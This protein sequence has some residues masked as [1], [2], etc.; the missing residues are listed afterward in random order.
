MREAGMFCFLAA[1]LFFFTACRNQ[2]GKQETNGAFVKEQSGG[3]AADFDFDAILRSGE[4]IV[5]TMSGPDTYYDFNG[6]ELGTQYDMC[7]LF[8]AQEGL[9]IRVELYNDTLQM[10]H[11][12]KQGDVDL[13]IFQIPQQVLA[14]DKD[15]T[16]AGAR[17]TLRHTSWAVNGKAKGLYDALAGWYDD[18]LWE[19]VSKAEEENS[20]LRRKVIRTPRAAYISKEKGIIS[21]YDAHFK[22]ASK[23]TGWDWRLIAAQCYVES[24]F[25]PN[26]VS[27]AGAQGLMQIMPKTAQSLHLTDV[28]NPV[29][30]IRAAARYI[31]LLS[32]SLS[33][34]PSAQERTLFV[35]A[36]YNG[37]LGHIEDARALAQKYGKNKNRWSDV[38]PYVKLLSNPQYYRDPVVKHGY[39]IGSETY[40][41]VEKIAAL[42]AQYGGRAMF[43][44]TSAT[45][46]QPDSHKRENKYT[47]G[48]KVLGV[49]E[50]ERQH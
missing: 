32:S 5:G 8:A 49:D 15:L 21:V 43:S 18:K 45:P 7:H 1:V 41:Y 46:V 23:T 24:A 22:E 25:D 14:K 2:N 38:A 30:N 39:M 36:S 6:K 26:A 4:L 40:E 47:K 11:A 28:F 16:A 34:I 19:E 33:S 29:E 17:D 35:L 3:A 44:G 20:K 42:Y 10:L 12:L 37:G 27:W 9:H 50:L 48:T 31:K 13:L